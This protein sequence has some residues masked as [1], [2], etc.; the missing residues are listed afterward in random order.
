MSM[1][2]CFKLECECGSSSFMLIHEPNDN[3]ELYFMC[4]CCH[5]IC[6]HTNNYGVDWV[7]KDKDNDE[8]E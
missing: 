3:N 8:D 4:E 6:G 7:E 2:N 5:E 1:K